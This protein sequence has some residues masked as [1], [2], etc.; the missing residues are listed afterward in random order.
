MSTFDSDRPMTVFDTPGRL[1]HRTTKPGDEGGARWL[2]QRWVSEPRFVKG[3]ERDAQ[4]R[5]ELRYDDEHGNGH[6]TFAI[7]G[8]VFVIHHGRR[9]D[10]A[11]GCLHEDIARVFRGL[12]PLIPWHLCSDDGPL[13]YVANTVYLAGD[14]D[15]WGLRAGE[16]YQ[17]K[18]RDGV[19]MW[20]LETTAGEPLYKLERS[21]TG[22]VPPAAPVLRWAPAL[23]AGEGKAR[24]LDAA[25]RVAIWPDAPDD[26]LTL[27]RPAL[28]AKLLERLP[29]LLATFRDLMTAAGFVLAPCQMSAA[30]CGAQVSK[31]WLCDHPSGHAGPH[32]NAFLAAK[33]G[34]VWG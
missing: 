13:H 23:R 31:G 24:D 11:C 4:L 7:T 15:H 20:T 17:L 25:R 3:Y 22:D 27:E 33:G 21:A 19:P 1:T 26:V 18:T 29:G 12:A 14:R 8:D 30:P 6:N 32:G 34:S 9:V 16:T 10:L 28:T 2:R 5:V